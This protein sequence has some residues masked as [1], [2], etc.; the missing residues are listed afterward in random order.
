MKLTSSLLLA[1]TIQT[2]NPL[3][4]LNCVT[5]A[6]GTLQC[7]MFNLTTFHYNVCMVIQLGKISKWILLFCYF[8]YVQ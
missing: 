1:F 2:I 3:Y 4:W 7:F 8:I 5:A 6:Y